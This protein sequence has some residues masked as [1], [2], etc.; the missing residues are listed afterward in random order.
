ME[1][2]DIPLRFLKGVELRVEYT[3]D[4]IDCGDIL[5]AGAEEV[6]MESFDKEDKE[7]EEDCVDC[8]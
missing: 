6:L 3:G 1:F 8:K 2:S 5:A 7:E 4:G